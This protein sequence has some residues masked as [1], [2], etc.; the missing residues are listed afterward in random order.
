M[1]LKEVEVEQILRTKNNEAKKLAKMA[2]LGIAQ[3]LKQMLVKYIPLL[4]I[5]LIEAKKMSFI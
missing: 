3:L 5:T 4:S 2:L 1:K